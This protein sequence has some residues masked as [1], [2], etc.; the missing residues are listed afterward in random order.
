VNT[1]NINLDF[2][3]TNLFLH[4][5]VEIINGLISSKNNLNLWYIPF[6]KN[7]E[8]ILIAKMQEPGDITISCD[9]SVVQVSTCDVNEET[10]G[11][12][13]TFTCTGG[14]SGGSCDMT[15]TV[16]ARIINIS[17]GIITSSNEIIF[18]NK[19]YK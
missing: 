17:T 15:V 13:T 2:K 16:E 5:N 19:K 18:N 7:E 9:C 14:C 6:D 1:A 8:P 12:T 4:K 3:N 11:G 10:N